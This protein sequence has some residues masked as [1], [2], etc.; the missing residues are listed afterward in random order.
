MSDW[1]LAPW[2]KKCPL[3]N[4]RPLDHKKKSLQKESQQRQRKS[5]ELL[6]KI[7]VEIN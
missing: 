5:S 6:I 7:T 1:V 4:E 2:H 3:K